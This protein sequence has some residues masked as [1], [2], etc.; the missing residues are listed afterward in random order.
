MFVLAI[1]ASIL[2]AGAVLLLFLVLECGNHC[3]PKL[4]FGHT[5]FNS[6][7]HTEY[8]LSFDTIVNCPFHG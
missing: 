3:V 5:V 1:S 8:C 4:E 7:V 2:M 6:A